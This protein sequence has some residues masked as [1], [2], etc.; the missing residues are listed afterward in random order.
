[1]KYVLCLLVSLFLF[2]PAGATPSE[3]PPFLAVY[4]NPQPGYEIYWEEE[5]E[6]FVFIADTWDSFPEFLRM[7]KAMA[8]DRKLVIN[9]S[10]HGG[11]DGLL[12]LSYPLFVQTPW[13]EVIAVN[14]NK[15]ASLGYVVNCINKEIPREQM[16]E[17]DLECCFSGYLYTKSIRNNPELRHAGGNIIEDCKEYPSFPIYGVPET[18]GLG[19]ILHLQRNKYKL[20][21]N[22]KDLRETEIL[23]VLSPV[24]DESEDNLKFDAMK[25]FLLTSG[26]FQKWREK[27][28]KKYKLH[29][30][31]KHSPSKDLYTIPK[32]PK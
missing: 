31:W 30:I 10:S 18:Y 2:L 15:Q 20:N 28:N 12:Y 1:M 25:Q 4:A 16:Q 5:K 32:P 11:E 3:K 26:E 17:L 27:F 13:G 21:I 22:Y 19:N 7:A 29:L 23:P 9:V 6:G 24:V 14:I 8:G